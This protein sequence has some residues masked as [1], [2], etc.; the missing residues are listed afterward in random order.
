MPWLVTG[1]ISLGLGVAN[2]ATAPLCELHAIRA[3]ARSSC[4]AMS[5][6]FGGAFLAA[7]IPLLVVGVGRRREVGQ[8]G[9][10]P[11]VGGALATWRTEF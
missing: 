5:L 8:V 2:I 6:A 7:G 1:G 11:T 3:S 9:V 4:V 10:A